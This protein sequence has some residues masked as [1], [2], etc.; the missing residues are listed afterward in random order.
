MKVIRI[1][2]LL[3]IFV[4]PVLVQSAASAQK[5]SPFGELSAEEIAMKQCSFDPDADAVVLL[6]EANSSYDDSYHLITRHH[7][8]IKILKE[9][10]TGNGD[11]SITF[12]RKDDYE[13]ISAVKAATFNIDANGQISS[14]NVE[15]KSI[16]R[17]N[18]NERIGEVV[19]SFP[20]VKVG[21]ILEYEYE[22]NMKNYG[23]LEDWYFQEKRPVMISRYNLVIVPNSEFTY[24]VLKRADFDAVVKNDASNGSV[25]FEMKNIPGLG[26]E[27]YMDSRKDY[28]Q[29]IIFQLS[30]YR[31][32][33]GFGG[34]KYMTSWAEVSR[35]LLSYSGFGG[36][37]GKN[38]PGTDDF[39]KGLTNVNSET[40][41]MKRVFEYVRSNLTWNHTY[42]KYAPDGLKGAWQKKTG[43]SAEINF[44]L[45]SLL[46][47]AGLEVYP[48]LVSY[49]R[50]GR[51]DTG[52]PFVDQ[53][54]SVIGC[55]K[56]NAV[57]H[58]L[59]ATDKLT[60]IHIIPNELLNTTAFIV[61]KKNG[62]LVTI[63]DS[64]LAYR[65][66]VFTDLKITDDG[67]VAGKTKVVSSE[68]AKVEKQHEYS[69]NRN[70]F[71]NDHFKKE[72]I[73]IDIKKLDISGTDSDS[74]PF[75]Q[76]CEFSAKLGASG[77]YNFLPLNLFSGFVSNPF[78][79][80]NR[81]S[82]INFGYK[83]SINIIT[84]ILLPA[85]FSVEELPKAIRLSNQ[86][87]DISMVRSAE[88]KKAEH[89][90][91]AVIR[92]EFS[93]SLYE[94]D[95]YPVLQSFYKKMF[96][97]LDEPVLLKRK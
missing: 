55:V 21:S 37:I 45:I 40:E 17:K 8:R 65:E 90:I 79:S 32:Q 66:A 92:I 78:I 58:Y 25:F 22:S 56:I 33:D 59:D 11:V 5:F 3:L 60:P 85:T 53:F 73:A 15:R 23:G 36:M 44:I 72:K 88:Y 47:E 83:R 50:H 87:K 97:Y 14:T 18:I 30:A 9:K 7:I 29:K 31:Q 4:L 6:H 46:K 82:N 39:I 54:T 89:S 86:E 2:Q 95:E 27:P 77:A 63:A 48:A 74:L 94:S 19:F 96:E 80:D 69:G 38:I 43:S 76:E 64:S 51:V 41:K 81:F 71:I 67:T 62:G 13:N 52:Y 35:E 10:G 49:R 26:N 34:S 75:T 1:R 91:L 68:Y 20:S 12:W 84:E 57:R 42:G 24:R 28:L 70:E 16:Y 93:K 61:H